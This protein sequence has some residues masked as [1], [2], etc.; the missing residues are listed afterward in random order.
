M[1][2]CGEFKSWGLPHEAW[3]LPLIRHGMSWDVNSILSQHYVLPF[4]VRRGGSL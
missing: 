1:F 2:S 3:S 4:S